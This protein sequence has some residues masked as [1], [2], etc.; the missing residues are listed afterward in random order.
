MT[1]YKTEN[2]S[3]L[4]SFKS[5]LYDL[6]PNTTYYVRAY[7]TNSI[8]AGYG[9][10]DKF[11]AQ[12]PAPAVTKIVAAD[13]SGDYTTVQAAFDGVPDSYTGPYTV[14]VKKGTYKEN[15]YWIKKVNVILMGEDQD[16]T[17]LIYDD[18]A[19][20]AGG[21]SG[22]SSVGIDAADF[23]AMNITFPKYCKK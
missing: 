2:G 1:D 22:L 16:S 4:G 11:K 15:F 3:G 12:S 23:T 9:E 17:V 7:A 21:T 5:I 14:F 18:Y 10:V 19:G 8:G 20:I 13:G 6:T